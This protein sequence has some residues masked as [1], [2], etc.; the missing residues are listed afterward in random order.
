MPGEGHLPMLESP[1]T[2]AGRYLVFI[3]SLVEDAS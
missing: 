2:T 3:D 1:E